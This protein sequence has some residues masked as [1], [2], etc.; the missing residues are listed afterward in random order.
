MARMR[1]DVQVGFRSMCALTSAANMAHP[2][3]SSVRGIISGWTTWWA[4]SGSRHGLRRCSHLAVHRVLF[5]YAVS[6]MC[7]CQHPL[8]RPADAS[9]P[10]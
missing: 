5:P 2:V 10:S 4:M 1:S 3:A 6:V 7:C 9:R 8:R